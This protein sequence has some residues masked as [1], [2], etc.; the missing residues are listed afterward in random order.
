MTI[1]VTPRVPNRGTCRI[2][3]DEKG[4][5]G[6]IGSQKRGGVR[7]EIG[8]EEKKFS[9]PGGMRLVAKDASETPYVCFA[10]PFCSP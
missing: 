3:R 2:L 10:A 4:V 7:V 5:R 1:Y 6:Q 9:G 8:A